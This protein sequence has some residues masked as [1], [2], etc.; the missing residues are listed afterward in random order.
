[1]RCESGDISDT[2]KEETGS[3][4]APNLPLHHRDILAVQ[5]ATISMPVTSMSLPLLHSTAGRH[6]TLQPLEDIK[7]NDGHI[8]RYEEICPSFMSQWGISIL[9]RAF[10]LCR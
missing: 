5:P 6:D 4:P 10:W 9:H 3:R 8:P 7:N 1:M 2:G